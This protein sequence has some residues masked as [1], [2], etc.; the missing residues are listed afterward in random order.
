MKIGKTVRKQKEPI[1]NAA[2][3]D[4]EDYPRVNIKIQTGEQKINQKLG[5]NKDYDSRTLESVIQLTLESKESDIQQDDYKDQFET[6]KM[7][8]KDTN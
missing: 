6:M 5:K 7:S 8:P 3:Q 4:L 1:S 2:N